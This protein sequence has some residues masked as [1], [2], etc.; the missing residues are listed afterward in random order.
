M[1]CSEWDKILRWDEVLQG[2]M[3]FTAVGLK[4]LTLGEVA[5]RWDDKY[6]SEM[7]RDAQ[8]WD[9]MLLLHRYFQSNPR[10]LPVR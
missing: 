7:E 10:H 4:A 1:R 5:Q 3:R 6:E 9:R 8:E 2:Q